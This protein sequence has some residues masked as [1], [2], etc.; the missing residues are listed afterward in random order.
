MEHGETDSVIPDTDGFYQ[1]KKTK[2]LY[3]AYHFRLSAHDLALFAALY[4]N[5]GAW[6]GRQIVP[7]EWIA[8]S[9][10]AY[11]VMNP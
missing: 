8:A 6:E 2:S 11:S 5:N 1:Y 10:K 3:P 7:A 9:T 4:L